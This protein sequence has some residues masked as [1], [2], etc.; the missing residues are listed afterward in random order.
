MKVSYIGDPVIITDEE[1]R[2]MSQGELAYEHIMSSV[3]GAIA[4]AAA[5][6]D[7]LARYSLLLQLKSAIKDLQGWARTGF[8]SS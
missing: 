5:M 8:F 3:H 6:P 4:T 7:T 2:N 1:I